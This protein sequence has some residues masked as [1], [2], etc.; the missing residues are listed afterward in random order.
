VE[1]MRV[2]IDLVLLGEDFE[3]ERSFLKNILWWNG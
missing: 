3:L 2:M 1:A